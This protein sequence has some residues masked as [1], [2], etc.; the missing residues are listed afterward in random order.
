MERSNQPPKPECCPPKGGEKVDLHYFQTERSRRSVHREKREP[1]A[2]P[3]SCLS[4]SAS[5]TTNAAGEGF[6]LSEPKTKDTNRG[7]VSEELPGSQSVAR[8]EDEARNWGSPELSR[9]TN[10]ESQAGKT[11]QPKEA[12]TEGVEGFGSAHS[13]QWQGASPEAGQGVDELTQ[14]AQATSTVRLTEQ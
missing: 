4:N 8:A 11:S 5:K 10:Y 3:A 1:Q 6:R 12:T 2:G 7:E 14:P 13:S 9:R